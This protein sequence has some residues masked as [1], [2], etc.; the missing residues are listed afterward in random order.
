MG[1]LWP[2]MGF[3]QPSSLSL[4]TELSPWEIS[5]CIIVLS[6]I[7]IQSRSYMFGERNISSGI[8][9]IYFWI[10]FYVFLYCDGRHD[11]WDNNVIEYTSFSVKVCNV[12]IFVKIQI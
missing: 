3:L 7:Q 5:L 2:L 9:D 1:F 11:S 8:R 12:D 6:K 10:K 4:I